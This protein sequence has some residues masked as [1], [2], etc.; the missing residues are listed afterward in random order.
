MGADFERAWVV[1]HP[2][3]HEPKHGASCFVGRR[4]DWV[5]TKCAEVRMKSYVGDQHTIICPRFGSAQL[6]R[7][8]TALSAPA[9][10]SAKDTVQSNKHRAPLLNKLLVRLQA[11]RYQSVIVM[12]PSVVIRWIIVLN[13]KY[14]FTVLI[15]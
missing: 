6:R 8:K 7:Y 12:G 11:N 2:E 1:V 15:T 10:T 5:Q 3:Q 9:G 4:V 14:L 13:V